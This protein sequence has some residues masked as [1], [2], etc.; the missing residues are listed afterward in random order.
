[1]SHLYTLGTAPTE[2]GDTGA[3]WDFTVLQDAAEH[4]AGGLSYVA[5]QAE[6]SAQPSH[7]PSDVSC[8]FPNVADYLHT[9]NLLVRLLDA[10][11]CKVTFER[12]GGL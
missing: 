3:Q 10:P 12:R 2:P 8:H 1:M 4:L 6:G 9:E 11:V 5:P 7:R